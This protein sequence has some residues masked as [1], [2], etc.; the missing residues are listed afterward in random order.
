MFKMSL[1]QQRSFGELELVGRLSWN[2]SEKALDRVWGKAVFVGYRQVWD[3]LCRSSASIGCDLLNS[4]GVRTWV[5]EV[6]L[7]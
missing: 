3:W 2:F 4:Q 7:R 6:C 5:F 1:E